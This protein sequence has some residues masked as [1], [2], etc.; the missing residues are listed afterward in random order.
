MRVS[1]TAG[2]QMLPLPQEIVY[3]EVDYG[4]QPVNFRLSRI[5]SQS[6]KSVPFYS[7]SQYPV[8]PVAWSPTGQFLAILR[9]LNSVQAEL[10]VLT[11][12]GK[13]FICMKQSVN[14]DTFSGKSGGVPFDL[15]WSRDEKSIFFVSVDS[16]SV[17]G[18]TFYESSTETGETLRVI[19]R[20]QLDNRY[21][22]LSWNP[23]HDVIVE[24][25]EEIFLEN[26]AHA[27][28]FVQ[29]DSKEMGKSI[30]IPF[31]YEVP[32]L[33]TKGSSSDEIPHVLTV[34]PF[35][36]KG[37]YVAAY[38]VFAR[39]PQIFALLNKRAEFIRSIQR[40]SGI[41]I[42]VGCPVWLQDDSSFIYRTASGNDRFFRYDI[43]TNSVE[44][45]FEVEGGFVTNGDFKLAE[46][47]KFLMNVSLQSVNVNKPNEN[48]PQYLQK[49]VVVGPKSTLLMIGN[50]F[51]D[52][53]YPLWVPP[54]KN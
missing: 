5:D 27:I 33:N 50:Q 41:P 44:L 48:I 16:A 2:I 10:C 31:R 45:V 17:E 36:P 30:K 25:V 34:C 15:Q 38:D 52:S 6:M 46:N 18:Y 32:S 49:I 54:L 28:N 24:G 23:D 12:E 39:N 4:Q 43:A 22:V 13:L 1:G 9:I 37:T 51:S 7:D 21:A 29:I 47:Q 26:A 8:Y 14:R 20:G 53:L 40:D 42:P 11:R 19:Y 35:S 3:L